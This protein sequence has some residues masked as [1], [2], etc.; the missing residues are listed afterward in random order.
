[1]RSIGLSKSYLHEGG[2]NFIFSSETSDSMC[3]FIRV[4]LI[5]LSSSS[6]PNICSISFISND[7]ESYEIPFL[8]LS[9]MLE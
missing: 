3:N 2:L 5:K 1:M 9:T 4:F 8:L 6:T 7:I